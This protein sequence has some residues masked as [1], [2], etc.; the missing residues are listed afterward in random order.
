MVCGFDHGHINHFNKVKSVSDIL[1][2]SV[3]NR[4]IKV[5]Y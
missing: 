3:L 4:F 2:V 5:P 1:V